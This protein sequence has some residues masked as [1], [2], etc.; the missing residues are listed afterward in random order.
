L[1]GFTSLRA[2]RSP[3]DEDG[4]STLTAVRGAVAT[5]CAVLEAAVFTDPV[6][7]GTGTESRA[8]T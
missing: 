8:A 4:R 5:G 6:A 2:S 7:T 3:F 1:V